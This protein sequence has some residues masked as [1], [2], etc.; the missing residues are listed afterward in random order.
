MND[1]ALDKF[2]RKSVNKLDHTHPTGFLE[3]DRLWE[4]LNEKRRRKTIWRKTV[5]TSVAATII[6]TLS[7]YGLTWQE[8][9]AEEWAVSQAG[10]ANALPEKEKHAMD[11]ITSH[12]AAHNMCNTPE[13]HALRQELAQSHDKLREIEKQLQLYGQDRALM[14]AKE[15]VERHQARLIKTIVQIL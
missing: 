11:F 10:V 4:L 13:L 14:R 2:I 3:P 8:R 12:C 9:G 7:F 5:W 1:D 6:I 15:R